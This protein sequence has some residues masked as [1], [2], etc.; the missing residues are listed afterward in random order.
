MKNLYLEILTKANEVFGTTGVLFALW[1]MF[2][3]GFGAVWLAVK[4]TTGRG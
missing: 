3:V 2:V 1:G 4:L